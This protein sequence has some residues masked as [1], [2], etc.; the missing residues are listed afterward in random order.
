MIQIPNFVNRNPEDIANEVRAQFEAGLGKPIYPGQYEQRLVN[1]ISYR[2][3]LLLERINAG[4]ANQ[5][6]QFST[7]PILDYIAGLVAVERLPAANAGCMVRF[8]LVAGHGGVILPMGTRVSTS[9]GLHI[10]EVVE[11]R[12]IAAGETEV[13][14]LATAQTAGRAANGVG[15]GRIDTILDPYAWISAVAN[16]TVT[17]G[18]SDVETDEALRERIRL[19]PSQF[20]TAGSRNSYIFHA[21][22]ANSSIIDVSV[23]SPV[24]GTVFIVPLCDGMEYEQVLRDIYAVCSA[25]DVRPLTDTVIVAAPTIRNYNIN[26]DIIHTPGEDVNEVHER[27]VE[28]LK[29]FTRSKSIRLGQS[30]VR[31]HIV[32]VCRVRG[33]FD[34]NVISPSENIYVDYGEVAD[35]GSTT[36]NVR[37]RPNNS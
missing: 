7:A 33:V 37:P 31:S 8:T 29:V 21:M 9:D 3:V 25:E 35:V 34:V 1:L 19:A 12:N 27:V 5:L 24:P 13:I 26:V 23:S 16:T 10:F 36:V 32:E 2:E 4:M 14:V 22:R 28:A 20:S 17:G 11:D 6:Y 15:I 18:G 30:V